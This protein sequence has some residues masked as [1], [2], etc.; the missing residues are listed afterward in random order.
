MIDLLSVV[1]LPNKSTVPKPNNDGLFTLNTC[2]R[3]LIIGVKSNSLKEWS[4]YETLYGKEAYSFLLEAICGL[5]S[6]L[7][8][9]NEITSQ[10][11]KAFREYLN[12][13]KK[14]VFLISV[15]EKLFKDAKEIKTIYL[16]K[17]GQQSYS[18]IAKKILLQNS[19]SKNV[20]I[21]GSGA[22]SL[23]LVKLLSKKFNLSITARNEQKSKEISEAFDIPLI[24]WGGYEDYQNSENIINTIGSKDILFNSNFFKKWHS[25]N[26]TYSSSKLF[27]DLGH[28]SVI[29][30]ELSTKEGVY[31]LS[32]IFQR[33]TLLSQEKTLKIQRAKKEID[34]IVERR[35]YSFSFNYPF[36]WEELHFA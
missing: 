34:N 3:T 13:P 18:A 2:Q 12:N 24:K 4:P 6:K 25:A 30:T 21:V 17:I 23:D 11:K 20:L 28:P 5:K 15:L 32:D 31:R 9:E 33:G 8:G 10:F 7:Q 26:T 35:F 36:G 14:N 1:H 19:E 29:D 22:I 16:S 27:I